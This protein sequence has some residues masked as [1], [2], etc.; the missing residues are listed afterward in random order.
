MTVCALPRSFMNVHYMDRYVYTKTI[1]CV[2]CPGDNAGRISSGSSIRCAG[3]ERRPVP[4]CRRSNPQPPHAVERCGFAGQL[5]LIWRA[6]TISV[7]PG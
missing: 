3:L 5:S 4:C 1:L 6:G 7:V 2:F